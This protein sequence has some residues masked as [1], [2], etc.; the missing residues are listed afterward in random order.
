MRSEST[1]ATIRPRDLAALRES[2]PKGDAVPFGSE[3]GGSH[4]RSLLPALRWS[5]ATRRPS[6][7]WW[8][9]ACVWLLAT[10]LTAPSHA[11]IPSHL[12]RHRIVDVRIAGETSGATGA[13]DVGI[14]L[15][16]PLT[17]RLLRSTVTRLLESGRW[18]DV[19][20]DAVPDGS[21]V[22]LVVYL[23]PRIVVTRV[24]VR[25]NELLDDEDVRQT[26]GLGASGELEEQD[27]SSL[28]EA[29]AE[30]Y[31]ERGY[32]AAR[33]T[34]HLRDTDDPTRK[35]LRVRIEEGEPVRVAAYHFDGDSPPGDIDIPG[36]IG[37]GVGDVLDQTRLREGL[38][39]A[40]RMLRREGFFESR[41]GEPQLVDAEHGRVTVTF[42]LR[43]GPRYEIRLLGHEPLERSSVEEVLQLEEERLT[44]RTMEALR[45]RVV[46]LLQRHGFYRAEVELARIQG[47]QPN[48]AVLEVRVR[49]GRQLHVVGM[50]F[51]GATHYDSDYLR[52][53]VI[54]VVEEDL[55]DTR[56]FGR[57]DSDTA[58]R[59]GLGGRASGRRRVPRPLEVDPGRVY[60]EP[61]Y[62]Q[63]VEHLGEVYQAAGFLSARVGPAR[64]QSVGPGRAIVVIPIVE[65]PRTLL[66]GVELRG[67]SLLGDR[68]LLEAA[69]LER[70]A[71]FSYLVLEEALTRMTELYHERG[72][73]YARVEPQVRFSQDRERAQVVLTV[74]ERF[75]VR[76]GEIAVE[77]AE[78]TDEAL[79]R[80]ALR[81]RQGD[82]FRPSVVRASQESLMA[83]GVFTSVN[84]TPQ[85]ADLPEQVK[86]VTV[87]VRERMPQYFDFQ[88]GISTGQGLRT[89]LEYGYRNLFGYA[90][91]VTGR[92]ELGFQFVFQD[93]DLR[94]NISGL[95]LDQRLERR[96]TLSF[97]LPHISGVSN[98]RASLDLVHLRDNQRLFGLDKNGV[99]LSFSWQ[100]LTR[101]SFTWSAELEQNDVQLFGNRE[102]FEDIIEDEMGNPQIARLLRVPQGNSIVVST[103]LSGALDQRDS[104]F[105]PT[106]GWFTSAAVEWVRTLE[107]QPQDGA[108]P[109][110]SHFLKFTG[111]LNGYLPLGEVV[112]ATQ[113]R[114]G[115]IVH[116]EDGSRTYPNRQFFLGGVD[117][118]RGFNQAQLQPQDAAEFQLAGLGERRAFTSLLSG[119]DFFYLLRMEVRF[120]IFESLQ[121]AVFGDFG[122]HWADPSTMTFDG[123]G[124]AASGMSLGT[125]PCLFVR[126]T[127]GLGLR[128]ATPVGPL[129]LDYGFNLLRR[130][131]L[132]EPF[133]AFHFSIGVF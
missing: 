95:P 58:D 54:S 85:N 122:N 51:P 91:N 100:P 32:P 70:N 105:V 52:G 22:S 29:V 25:G 45:E 86:P 126:P 87:T 102:N 41:L 121:G 99:A 90:L 67:N 129:A 113:I 11:Q 60:Y 98:L 81:F 3:S 114:A 13:R 80:E 33:T 49:P 17:R 47:D 55:P 4:L 72:Y 2:F 63:A 119:G 93:D 56:M 15:G 6:T 108:E 7:T 84:I 103:R 82:L 68:L 48:T 83:L 10:L 117:S 94:D 44:R 109:F 73:I 34:L 43:L 12:R 5:R 37:I 64:L 110:F 20:I 71:P 79:I 1:H 89:S 61:L 62:A 14:P 131:E 38:R 104:P 18:A 116:L 24:E 92:A 36:A 112:V 69:R 16:A 46:Q 40:S 26:L 23:R 19:Q 106:E 65:G 76:F 124:A 77:G 30:A 66:F 39:N 97:A 75:E 115:G 42:P 123:C 78:R 53:Q 74:V 130:D 9:G 133:G 127:A 57:V 8:V 50:S 59:L 28:A 35:V 21:G 101:L 27:L 118:L 31:K 88:L 125:A 96:I 107:T 132:N 111:T 120:P 128:L